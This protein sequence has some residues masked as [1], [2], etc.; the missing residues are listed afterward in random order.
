MQSTDLYHGC[1][2]GPGS[3]VMGH[4]SWVMG[5]LMGIDLRPNACCVKTV[6]IDCSSALDWT[7]LLESGSTSLMDVACS[8]TLTVSLRF[9]SR[10]RVRVLPVRPVHILKVSTQSRFALIFIIISMKCNVIFNKLQVRN[11]DF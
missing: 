5:P 9:H 4:G 3:R 8:R 1:G 6:A 7:K 11:L 2:I 10:P